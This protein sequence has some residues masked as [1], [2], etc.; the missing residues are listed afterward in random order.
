[1]KRLLALVL[2][3][4]LAFTVGC[5]MTKKATDFNGLTDLDGRQVMHQSTTNV[6]VHLLF[7]RPLVHDATLQR[8]VAD[9]TAEA[10][11]SG[12]SGVRIVQSSK[13]TY[14]WVLPPISFVVHP[15]VTNVAG[16]VE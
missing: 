5:T 12:A 13:K 7:K 11:S 14:W 4:T 6:A 10:D 15:V 2:A 1:M 3:G 8:T 9:F 16:D